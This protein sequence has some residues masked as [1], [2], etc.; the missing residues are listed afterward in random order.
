MIYVNPDSRSNS[1]AMTSQPPP[2]NKWTSWLSQLYNSG[3]GP[4]LGAVDI[5]EIED[6]A[7]EVL[8]DND[9]SSTCHCSYSAVEP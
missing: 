8:K 6:K 9:N 5:Q 1:P 3:K 2:P 4:V 7:R